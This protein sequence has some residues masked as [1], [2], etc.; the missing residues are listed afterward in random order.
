MTSSAMPPLPSTATLPLADWL[1]QALDSHAD[2]PQAVADGLHERAAALPADDS[3][4]QAV[5]LAEHLWLGHLADTA[6]LADWLGRLPPALLA[7]AAPGSGDPSTPAP[8]PALAQALARCH[9]ALAALQ[10]AAHATA[11][12]LDDASRWRALQNVVLALAQQG[13]SPQA[14]SLLLADE[15]AAAAQGD[16]DA[17]RAFAACANNVA[18]HLHDQAGRDAER[19]QLMLD[20]AALSLRAW[21]RAGTWLHQQRAE[22]RLALCHAALGQ[23]QAALAHACRCL[24]GCQQGDGTQPADAVEHFCAHEA[25]ARAHHAAGDAAGR[26]AAAAQMRAL[27]P[28]ID[29]ADGLRAWCAQALA[30]LPGA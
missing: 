30:D 13:R 16:S 11:P 18:G 25:L 2:S 7:A 3:G 20:A 21:S 19:D 23:G 22:Y 9:W 17:G 5:R 4:A 1:A 6:G 27:L 24:Q 12:A 26:Q 8:A 29:E 14:R 28:A 10:H 15:D